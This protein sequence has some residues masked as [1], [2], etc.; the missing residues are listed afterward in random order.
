VRRQ[1]GYLGR[2]GMGKGKGDKV[3]K[4]VLGAQ[5]ECRC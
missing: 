2:I 1:V 4:E 3:R 5:G